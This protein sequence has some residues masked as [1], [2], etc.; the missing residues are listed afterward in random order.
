MNSDLSAFGN[1][2]DMVVTI[3]PK[4]CLKHCS[5]VYTN[6]ATGHRIVCTCQCHDSFTSYSNQIDVQGIFD[7]EPI[8]IKQSNQ[9]G[10]NGQ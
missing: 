3:C 9:E 6:T 1:L 5:R 4:G 8:L 2:K 7:G 10:A